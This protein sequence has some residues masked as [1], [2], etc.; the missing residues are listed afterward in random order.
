MLTSQGNID[1]LKSGRDTFGDL[2]WQPQMSSMRIFVKTLTGKT[3]TLDVIPTERIDDVKLKIFDKEGIPCYQSAVRRKNL[4][5]STQV[6]NFLKWFPPLEQYANS[7][8]QGGA[9][10]FE[11]LKLMTDDDLKEMKLPVGHRRLLLS[12]IALIPNSMEYK[13]IVRI[14][15][16]DCKALGI[17][18]KCRAIEFDCWNGG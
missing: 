16:E 9:T 6:E 11:I 12:K 3:I 14:I 13:T 4:L 2:T 5:R 15:E 17:D 10:T 8:V 1:A 18:I 7:L